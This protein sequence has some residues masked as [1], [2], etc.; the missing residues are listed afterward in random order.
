MK[1]FDHLVF[2]LDEYEVDN[3][4]FQEPEFQKKM[5]L[6]T[7]AIASEKTKSPKIKKTTKRCA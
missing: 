3:F 6:S 4:I 1:N 7:S 2:F 5:K